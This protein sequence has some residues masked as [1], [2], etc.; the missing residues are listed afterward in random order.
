MTF[1]NISAISWGSALSGRVVMFHFACVYNTVY[2]GCSNT[3]FWQSA[4][5]YKNV[6]IL[7]YHIY[8]GLY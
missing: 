1:N 7:L 4:K 6:V 8:M 2:N 5:Q 3:M